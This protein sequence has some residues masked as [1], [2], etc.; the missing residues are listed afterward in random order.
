[1]RAKYSFKNIYIGVLSQII[2]ILLGFI[3]RKVFLDNLGAEYLGVNGLMT[4]IISAMLLIEAGIG[5][6]I[7]Y[8]LYKPLAEDDEEKIIALVQL[9]RKAYFILAIIMAIF[10]IIGYYFLDDIMKGESQIKNIGFVYFLFVI[11]NIISYLYAYKWALINA[12]Q[13]GYVLVKNNLIFQIISMISKIIILMLTKNYIMYLSIEIVIFIIQNM[14]NSIIVNK[15]YS[16]IKTNKKYKIDEKTR[17]NIAKNVKAMFMQNIGNYII[18]S[19][20]N[21][22]ISSMI[23]V[24][25]V[26]LYSNYTMIIGQLTGL[27]QPIINGISNSVGNL[28]ATET[29]EKTYFIF[30]ITFLVSFWLY[31]FSVIFLYNLLDPFISWWIGE[32]YIMN[33][34]TVVI[35]LF[36]LYIDGMQGT[37]G[38]FKGK[39]GLFAQDK[40]IPLIQGLI[41]LII[42]ITLI[43]AIGLP[44]VFLGTTCSYL[45]LSFWNQPRIVFKHYFN[46]SIREYFYRYFKL[47]IIGAIVL[48]ITTNLCNV[49][50]IGH[51]FLSLVLRGVICTI[52]VNGIYIL[53]FK[54]TDEFKYLY[55]IISSSIIKRYNLK[56]FLKI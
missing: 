33:K 32:S 46:R 17:T 2:I 27:I 9:Y 4:N 43:K 28:I 52:I 25:V 7:V 12:D 44:G 24:S 39:T 19:T 53:V 54:N 37:I 22:L 40:Y 34:I 50:I 41:N 30:N 18:F 16:Y 21:I 10:S 15:R 38:L 11:K 20:D 1:M 26:G 23:N 51:S 14:I 47:T 45:V 31:S 42:S 48:V 55:N 49:F 3:S 5:T 8:N 35:L 29:K 13:R 6:S 56:Y 36:N